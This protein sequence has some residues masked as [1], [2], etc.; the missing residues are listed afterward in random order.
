MRMRKQRLYKQQI[1][2]IMT[3]KDLK[4][5]AGHSMYNRD[6]LARQ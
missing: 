4:E 3:D 5:I 2:M 6:E 1:L